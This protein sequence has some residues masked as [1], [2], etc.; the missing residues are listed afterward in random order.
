LPEKE[1]A[2]KLAD[3]FSSVSQEYKHLETEDIKVPKFSRESTPHISVDEVADHLKQ[4]KTKKSTA[5]GDIPAKLI[6]IS[7]DHLAIP[8]AD[9]INTGIRLG[10]WPDNYKIETITPVPKVHPPKLLDQLR[11]ISNLFTYSK[12]GEKIISNLMVEDMVKKM[13]PS[14][15]GNLKRTSIQHYLISSSTGSCPHWT[16]IRRV[17]YSPDVLPCSIISKLFLASATS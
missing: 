13:D 17:T 12:V 4:I 8:L 5:P 9:V 15:F 2:E 3:H 16:T 6:K 1:Q 7:A 14:Q 11:P 10:Q